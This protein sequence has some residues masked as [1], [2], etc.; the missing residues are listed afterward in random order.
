MNNNNLKI[1][2]NLIVDGIIEIFEKESL[3]IKVIIE[4]KRVLIK[5]IIIGIMENFK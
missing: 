1:K 2:N 4:L 5:T 3:N